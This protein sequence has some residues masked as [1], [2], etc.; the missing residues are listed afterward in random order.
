MRTFS[1]LYGQTL[2]FLFCFFVVVNCYVQAESVASTVAVIASPDHQTVKTKAAGVAK[3]VGVNT[4]KY[5]VT[6]TFDPNSLENEEVKPVEPV[7][8]TCSVKSITFRPPQGVTPVPTNPGDPTI[9]IEGIGPFSMVNGSWEAYVY[10]PNAGT[11]E[12]IFEVTVT[13]DVWDKIEDKQKFKD[14]GKPEKFTCSGVSNPVRFKATAGN[15]R[16]VLQP[17]DNFAGRSLSSLGV[18]ETGSGSA[19]PNAGMIFVEPI[20]DTQKDD[21]FPL[22]EFSSSDI[23]AFEMIN[24]SLLCGIASF[25]AGSTEGNTVVTAKDKN[26]NEE[27]YPIEILRPKS[28]RMELQKRFVQH[29]VDVSIKYRDK[30]YNVA[31]S[32]HILLVTYIEPKEVSFCRIKAYEGFATYKLEGDEIKFYADNGVS[33]IHD[34]WSPKPN[35]SRGNATTG[36]HVLGPNPANLVP[37]TPLPFDASGATRPDTNASGDST[38]YGPG[39]LSIKLPWKY[40]V[41]STVGKDI[42]DVDSVMRF[43]GSKAHITKQSVTEVFDYFPVVINN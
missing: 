23:N 13:Y 7:N 32:V 22:Q 29:P 31:F 17:D 18:G 4:A 1:K 3:D 11:W 2:L 19:E 20:G 39:K 27:T 24:P 8:W 34:E 9:E 26:G 43:D 6:A 10:S 35:V 14:D 5:T 30:T 25:K 40:D 28:I 21:I 15:F 12:I 41:G 37:G 38:G 16:I 33:A 36:C 42:S